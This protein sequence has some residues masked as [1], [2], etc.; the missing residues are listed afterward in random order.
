MHSDAYFHSIS[1]QQ[2]VS[3]STNGGPGDVCS[4]QGATGN[5]LVSY[6]P[7]A[8]TY[9]IPY[10]TPFELAAPVITDSVSDSAT[11]YCWEEWDLGGTGLS[12]ANTHAS[13]P[14]FRS[15]VPTYSNVRVF[16]EVSMVL[17][18]TLSN[19]GTEGAE[20]EK[21]PDVARSLNFKCTFRDILNNNYGCF[22]LPDDEITL[23]AINTGAGFAVTSQNTA[24]LAYTGGSTT[25][26]TWNVVGTNAS[27]I[28]AAT[29]D[30]SMSYDGGNTWYY[31]VGTFTNNGSATVTVPNP[32]TTTSVAR[33][34]V[35]GSGNVFFNVN[36]T[37]F[38]VYYN[39]ALAV[40]SGV[41]QV[42]VIAADIKIF[43][44][45]A[46]DVLH[47]TAGNNLL[48]GIVYNT[49]GQT[50]WQGEINGNTDIPVSSWATGVYYMRFANLANGS[51]TVKSF[52]I[53]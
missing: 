47:I 21:V 42:N 35:K 50:I 11:L 29:V 24:G 28:N 2:I 45:P 25:V 39:P 36:S 20:G 17:S 33:F 10:L 49:V 43:P 15:Y 44:V 3:Y 26:I 6:T 12:F 31:P 4:V 16:P 27:P 41:R 13:G 30:I 23:N 8:A 32:A 14:L 40:S 53:Q 52:V 37:D 5:K 22:T 19:A 34:K 38:T 46:T 7:F 48:H 1:L 18:G 9:S 51:I